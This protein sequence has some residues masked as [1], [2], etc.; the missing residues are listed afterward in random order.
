MTMAMTVPMTVPM[1][2][3]RKI[4]K[5]AIGHVPA[6]YRGAAIQAARYLT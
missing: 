5:A 6:G 3:V 1:K 2:L 4:A